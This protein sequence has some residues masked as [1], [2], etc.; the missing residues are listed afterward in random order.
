MAKSA[1]THPDKFK[2]TKKRLKSLA[3]QNRTIAIA[4]DFRVDGAKSPEIP[5]KEGVLGSE[6]ATRNRKSLATFHRTPKSQC[7]VSEIASDFWGPR[8]AFAI[9][10]RENRCDFGALSSKVTF[11]VPGKVTL[12]KLLRHFHRDPEATFESLF[13]VFEFFGADFVLAKDPH[14]KDPSVLKIVR[15]SN[16]YYFDTAVVFHFLYRFRASFAWKNKH[17]WALSVAFA[18]SVPNLLP[19]PKFTLRSIFSTGGS[20]WQLVYYK[21]LPAYFTA[22]WPFVRRF[23]VLS[24]DEIGP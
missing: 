11:G 3:H 1:L 4:S 23:W 8:W 22:K 10:N 21:P 6:I 14:P 19:V 13:R 12:E 7:K 2:G 15:R 5:Q 20:L 17:F 9:A 24:K 16:P 18:A